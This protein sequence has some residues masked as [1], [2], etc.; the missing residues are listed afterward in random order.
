MPWRWPRSKTL[1]KR[2]LNGEGPVFVNIRGEALRGYKHWFD[3]AVEESGLK[4][5]TWY[6]LRHTFVSRL[7]MAG[8][9]LVTISDL[10]GHNTIQM[11]KRYAHLAPAHNQAAVDRLVEFH[12]E[13]VSESPRDT[14]TGTAPESHAMIR[15]WQVFSK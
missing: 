2:S 14:K 4:D 13:P 10:M 11:T 15:P 1:Q 9:S 5:F 8:V 12:A 3:P 7:A 6:C